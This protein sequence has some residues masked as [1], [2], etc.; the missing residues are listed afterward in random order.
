M[1]ATTPA[2]LAERR[3]SAAAPRS[4]PAHVAAGLQAIDADD[5][6][7]RAKLQER[8]GAQEQAA[9]QDLER[10]GPATAITRPKM[11]VPAAIIVSH[12]AAAKR[13]RR[14]RLPVAGVVHVRDRDR[15][16]PIQPRANVLARRCR[17]RTRSRHR[18]STARRAPY[19]RA[20]RTRSAVVVPGRRAAVPVAAGRRIDRT[21][22]GPSAPTVRGCPAVRATPSTPPPA[23]CVP[24]PR[25][26]RVDRDAGS[27][28]PT[29]ACRPR[30]TG[31]RLRPPARPRR[32]AAPDGAGPGAAIRLHEPPLLL[33]V[34]REHRVVHAERIGDHLL[35]QRHVVRCPR[36][37]PARARAAPCRGCCRGTRNRPTS[38]R[39]A[40][41]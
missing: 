39:R 12:H 25:P 36:A 3:T 30:S 8:R 37:R 7:E 15:R 13:S 14:G 1:T 33:V 18:C 2:A 10:P 24:R 6:R 40:R 26:A 17:R 31:T 21:T 28:P 32:T 9:R 20:D 22:R 29:Q 35:H 19:P 34:Q 23:R 41:A 16:G 27:P 11:N 4:A 5:H 38:A